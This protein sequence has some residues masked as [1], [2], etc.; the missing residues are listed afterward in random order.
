[1]NSFNK[2][3]MNAEEYT[4]FIN[5][6]KLENRFIRF[7][8]VFG[9]GELN[10][11]P[12][13]DRHTGQIKGVK[14]L[15][16]EEKRGALYWVE[17][18]TS[19]KITNETILDLSIY[20]DAIDWAWIRH[21]KGIAQSEEDMRKSDLVYFYVYDEEK[22]SERQLAHSSAVLQALLFISNTPDPKLSQ[23]ARLLGER[24]ETLKPNAIREFLNGMAKS[25]DIEKVKK[26]ISIY[27]DADAKEKTF[28]NDLVDKGIVRLVNDV[29]K[30]EHKNLG[31][32][33]TQAVA[34]LKQKENAHLVVKLRS[35]LYPG[36]F[37]DH[38][39]KLDVDQFV[40]NKDSGI[41]EDFSDDF[42]DDESSILRSKKKK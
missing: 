37:T 7:K 6:V 40:V 15:T 36:L 32:G 26:I 9:I 11:H 14:P 8:S 22:E 38:D 19:R 21:C 27:Q 4:A 25:R 18:T 31:I 35:L 29:Y 2:E 1:M 17:P 3:K 42:G 33:Q 13:K 5:N 34:F 30:F 41:I 10:L 20:M 28:L 23:K 24:M 12:A 39:Y 16:E